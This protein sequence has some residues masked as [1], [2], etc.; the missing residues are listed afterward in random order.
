M[1]AYPSCQR[2]DGVKDDQPNVPLYDARLKR[3]ESLEE[4]ARIVHGKNGHLE[5]YKMFVL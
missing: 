2:R 3:L 1:L 5:R 4:C